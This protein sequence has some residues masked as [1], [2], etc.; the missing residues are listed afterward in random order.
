ML[1]LGLLYCLKFSN[2]ELPSVI[3]MKIARNRSKNFKLD[4]RIVKINPPLPSSPH[5]RY[6]S[7]NPGNEQGKLEYD[8]RSLPSES[9]ANDS[10]ATNYQVN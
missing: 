1:Y 4:A 8:Q 9:P 2:F 7:E 6:Y 5:Q 10:M 3:N